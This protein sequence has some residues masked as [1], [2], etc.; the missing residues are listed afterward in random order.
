MANEIR[1][2]INL[3]I[4]KGN[5]RYQNQP[6][7]FVADLE[8]TVPKISPGSVT[9]P[10][11]GKIIDLSEITTPGFTVL[12]NTSDDEDAYVEYGVYDPATDTFEPFGELGPGESNLVK[13][14][15]NF[16]ETYEGTG[17]GTTGPGKRFF[18]KANGEECV[19]HIEVTER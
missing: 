11:G 2:G 1:V 3:S 8:T 9:V 10:L 12:R 18:M 15:R 5:F 14:S 19:V 17:T 6:T 16:R 13:L 4:S 7:G